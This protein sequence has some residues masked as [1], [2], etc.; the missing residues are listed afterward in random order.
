MNLLVRRVVSSRIPTE[1][2]EFQLCLYDNNQDTKEHLA[3]VLGEV[4]G[5]SDVLVRVHSECFTGDVLGSQRCDCGEQLH[6]AMQRISAAGEGVLVYLRQEGR[7]IG[8][9]EKLRAYNLQDEGFDTVD[10]NLLLGHQVDERDYTVAAR[11]LE[12]LGVQS[13]KLMTNNPGKLARLQELG[14]EVTERIPLES[15]VNAENAGY[16]LTKAQRMHHL[17]NLGGI[18]AFVPLHSNGSSNGKH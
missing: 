16:L 8:L 13:I 4:S 10:A 17:L 9:T 6:E 11:I 12:D 15:Q 18:P 14:V 1:A 5:H 2:G 7:G 3:L